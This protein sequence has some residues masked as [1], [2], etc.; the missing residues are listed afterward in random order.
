MD[1]EGKY[2]N[3]PPAVSLANSAQPED[4]SGADTGSGA[5]QLTDKRRSGRE[6]FIFLLAVDVIAVLIYFLLVPNDVWESLSTRWRSVASLVG[7]LISYLGLKAAIQ[8][9]VSDPAFLDQ[10]WFRVI[11][12][13]ASPILWAAV[14]PVWSVE[15]ELR[16]PQ[17]MLTQVQILNADKSSSSK[18]NESGA[19]SVESYRTC[20]VPGSDSAANPSANQ[21]TSATTC[22]VGGLLLRSYGI[23]VTGAPQPSYLP[24]F[25]ILSN[26]V[27]GRR[28]RIQ[29]PCELEIQPQVTGAML[30]MKPQGGRD[31]DGGTLPDDGRIWL[32][33]GHYD[34]VKITKDNHSA[35]SLWDMKCVSGETLRLSW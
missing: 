34:Y 32:M 12:G 22:K 35:Q 3:S 21:A 19:P 5:R 14:L 28:L 4:K 10:S 1:V 31:V 8:R 15:L 18:T 27:T 6:F 25:S 13:F 9:Y 16:P 20:E 29:L 30:H 26:M 23:S 2:E 17:P 24:A 7:S 33:P 11:L